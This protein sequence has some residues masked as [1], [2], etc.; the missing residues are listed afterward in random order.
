MRKTLFGASISCLFLACP[1]QED[2]KAPALPPPVTSAAPQAM[3]TVP[4]KP[5]AKPRHALLAPWQGPN[6]GLPTFANVKADDLQLALE[7]GIE[8][9]LANIQTIADDAAP[10]TF[11]NTIVALERASESL[12]RVE[13]VYGIFTSTMNAAQIQA[14]ERAMDPKLTALADTIHQNKKLFDRVASI[15]EARAKLGLSPE[16]ARVVWLHHV[17]FVRAGAKLSAADKAKVFALNQRL[18]TLHT[19]F[20]QNI[21]K[22][23]GEQM[24]VLDKE[25]DLAGLSPALL[26]A[27]KAAAESHGQKGKFAIVNTRSSVDPF[28]TYST[29]RDLREKVWRMFMMRGDNGGAADNNALITEI[30]ELRSQRAKLLGYETHAHYRLELSMAKTPDRAITLMESVWKPAV[31]R[32]HEEVRDMQKIADREKV[33]TTIEPWDYRYYAEKVRKAKYDLDQNEVKPYLSLESLREGMFWVAGELLG[34]K[35]EELK[36]ELKGGASVY[37]PDVRIFRV[38]RD[39]KHIG[40]WYFDPY[41]RQG[42]RSGAWMNAYRTQS[43]MAGNVSTIVSN[44]A[45]F[46]KGAPG[47]AVQISWDDARTLFHEFGHALHGL[48]SNVVYPSVAGTHVARDYVEFPS[49]LLERWLSTPEVLS[50]FALHHQTKQPIP[51]ALVKKLE[52][53]ATFNEGFTTV[54]YLSSA[55]IDMKMHM[56]G[57]KKI[58]PRAFEK[59]TLA[60]LGM[61]KEMIMRHRAPHFAHIFSGESYSAGYYSYLWSD[62]LSA[63]AFEAFKE[64]K[65]PYDKAVAQKLYDHVLSVGNSVDPTEGY[66][67]FRGKDAG[68]AAL[69]RNRGFPVPAPTKK[70]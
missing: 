55:L 16:Q 7:Q 5:A 47:E 4:A 25:D 64:A 20:G 48:S 62:T 69:M 29:R 67:S 45:N 58:E 26:Q 12:D 1:P 15:Y 53:S 2:A 28:L 33:K 23:E 18:S 6:G 70:Q 44:N 36:E 52:R 42:K 38:N 22:E 54:E 63:D 49:Q 8:E 56:Q 51:P 68:S 24:V 59:D 60:S 43:K 3:N 34:L 19:Q 27:A 66:R 13:A 61:P 14:V 30:V 57:D 10:P 39:G 21:L 37:H 9:T 32:V 41:A 31:A 35:F 17:A 50:R 65:G 40:H 46:V 11:D